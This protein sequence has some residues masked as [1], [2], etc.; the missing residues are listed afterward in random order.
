[1]SAL[2]ALRLR[3]LAF[4]ALAA[5]VLAGCAETPGYANSPTARRCDRTGDIDERQACDRR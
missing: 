1:M 5:F 3:R 2:L 4:A